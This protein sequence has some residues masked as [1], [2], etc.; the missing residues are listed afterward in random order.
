M[1]ALTIETFKPDK[2]I[3]FNQYAIPQIK[4]QCNL[5]CAKM[6]LRPHA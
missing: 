6:W 1:E 4:I 3:A 5:I 2:I